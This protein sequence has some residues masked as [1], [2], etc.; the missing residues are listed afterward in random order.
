[1]INSNL[2]IRGLKLPVNL[3]WPDQEREQEQI[4]S[5]DL[6]IIFPKPPLACITD[7]LKDTV[8]YAALIQTLRDKLSAQNF[9]LIE[10]LGQEI[11]C[12]VK[13]QF[14]PDAYITIH[15]TKNPNIEGLTNGVCFSYYD[16]R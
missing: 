2:H 3:G 11:Y 16:A 12:I 13:E 1:M 4:V 10:H 15:I 7:D 9:H 8:C 14:P 5:L 6:E